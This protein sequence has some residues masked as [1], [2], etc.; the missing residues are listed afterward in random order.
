[1]VRWTSA[2]LGSI[3]VK[4]SDS[5]LATMSDFSS[6]VRY[7]WCGSLPVAMRLVSVQ[8]AGLMTLT[9]ASS[10]LSTKMGEVIDVAMFWAPAGKAD[11]N[12]RLKPKANV[13]RLDKLSGT[14]AKKFTGF[15]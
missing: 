8:V 5:A 14:G 2:V 6:G 13:A 11:A 4:V 9:L 7:R 12:P 3:K 1:M 10:E 15:T